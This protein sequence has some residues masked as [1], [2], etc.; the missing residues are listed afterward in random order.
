MRRF[1]ENEDLLIWKRDPE[2]MPLLLRG[3]RQVGK[4]FLVENFG[5]R[6]F[7]H[8]LIINFEEQKEYLTCFESLDIPRILSAIT[9]L[10][11]QAIIPGET[12]LFLDEIQ[13]CPAAIMSLRYFKEKMPQLHVIGAGS[14]LEFALKQ[15]GFHMPVGRVQSLYVKP[16][17]FYEYLMARGQNSLID[18]LK[19]ML[20]HES[21]DTGITQKLEA[22]LREYFILGGM[23]AVIQ[24]YLN[25]GSFDK[26]PLLQQGLLINYHDDFGKY[27][28]Q[29]QHKYLQKILDRVP[30]MVGERFQ[31][32]HV[33]A[34]MQSRDLKNA[35]DNLI[36]AGLMYRIYCTQASGLPLNACLQE[37]FFKMLFLDIGLV[38]ATS[39]LS[40]YLMLKEDLM[41][42]NRGMLTEQFV[43]QELLA[44]TPRYLPGQ[45]FYWKREKKGAQAEIDY[46]THLDEFIIPMEVKSGKT[47]SLKSL[48]YFLNSFSL[49]FGIHLSLKPLQ[50]HHNILSVPLYMIPEIPRL[51]KAFLDVQRC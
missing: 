16:L 43:G 46:V 7:Q 29:N 41:L 49:P 28:S 34:H 40:P 47:G 25:T 18:Y 13:V 14:L 2:R 24:S 33:D 5:R 42:I 1:I 12:L 8:L 35:L 26:T 51:A 23:P 38:K 3:A 32:A 9:A 39:F 50:I 36:D 20:L 11:G 19:N 31:Y 37:K 45:L 21:L 27:A 4:S 48:H 17:S 44:N 10:S 30:G 22:Y 6:H 15:E